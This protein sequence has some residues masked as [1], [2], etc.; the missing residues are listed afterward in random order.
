ML[1]PWSIFPFTS[2]PF[3]SFT[4]VLLLSSPYLSLLWRNLHWPTQVRLGPLI[5]YHGSLFSLGTALIFTCSSLFVK[6]SDGFS[7]RLSALREQELVCL[8]HCCSFS[9]EHDAWRTVRVR[10]HSLGGQAS[11]SHRFLG[12]LDVLLPQGNLRKQK[13]H[14]SSLAGAFVKPGLTYLSGHMFQF[15]FDNSPG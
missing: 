13:P 11:I 8:S 1:S 3:A 2:Y 15:T 5:F 10:I 4:L 9:T 6:E 7:T 14:D 12:F